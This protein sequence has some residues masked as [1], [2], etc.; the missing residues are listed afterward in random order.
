[1]SSSFRK[2][3]S[4]ITGSLSSLMG[5][6]N[7][8]PEGG[9]PKQGEQTG[10]Q[11]VGTPAMGQVGIQAALYQT[12]GGGPLAAPNSGLGG[13]FPGGFPG[14]GID[15]NGL[16]MLGWNGGN[17]VQP[18]RGSYA[19]Y[20][21]MGL[22]ATNTLLRILTYSPII[23]S[24]WTVQAAEGLEVD[25]TGTKFTFDKS[26]GRV[27]KVPKSAIDFLSQTIIAQRP[28]IIRESVRIK[29][30]GW[31]P[32][33]R[34]YKIT[35]GG[36]N[37]GKFYQL[38]KLKP[39]LPEFATIL[40]DEYGNFGGLA[41]NATPD[42]YGGSNLAPNKAW[43]CS[44]DV[45]AGNMYG[46]SAYEPGYDPYVST[47]RTGMKQLLL[48]SKLSGVLPTL[49]Y[50]PGSTPVP[51]PNGTPAGGGAQMAD[52]FNIAK[53]I[54]SVVFAGGAAI[55]PTTEYTDSDLQQNPELAGLAPWKLEIV[56]AGSYSP[57]MDGMI[58]E[59]E[60]QD[61]LKCR[62][63]GWPE[64][65]VLEAQNSGSRADST[66]HTQSASLM[67]ENLDDD[68]AN[69]VSQGQP[70][71]G[72]PGV[73]DELLRLNWGEGTQGSIVIRPAPLSDPKIQLYTTIITTL[74]AN[75]KIAPVLVQAMDLQDMLGHLDIKTPE[76][77]KE[78]LPEL[79]K[80]LQQQAM[81]PASPGK[82]PIT[83]TARMN[84]V[85]NSNGNGNNDD[86]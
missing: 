6:A 63:W 45:E 16:G 25:E 31:R 47:I 2:D 78:K 3:K 42:G 1:M 24:Q 86:N 53:Q 22:D 17:F 13:V 67:L 72:V 36:P 35:S 49:Y 69:Q 71:Y 19:T 74:L 70:M 64:R 11:N 37:Q 66:T 62:A 18:R 34:V 84:G 59:R 82:T 57:A 40:H 32:F 85:A 33:E 9:K 7:A 29:E 61:K 51:T 43:I 26:T 68:I 20:R 58:R 14:L 27:T 76:D 38:E 54:V 5:A 52:N 12:A 65:A 80:E 21:I 8:M 48:M 28:G 81:Q 46:L 50:R 10:P 75:P 4:D 44:H 30:F 55:V 39:I 41:T 56:D 60:Y 23:A 15:V 73:I 79:L 83:P 77:F